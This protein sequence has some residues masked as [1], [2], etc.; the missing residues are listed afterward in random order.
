[1]TLTVKQIF[2]DARSQNGYL[3][4]PVREDALRRLYETDRHRSRK[5]S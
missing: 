3:D 4:V 1:M 5:A 2:T